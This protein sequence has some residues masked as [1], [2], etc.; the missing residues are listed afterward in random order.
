MD[1]PID[2]LH[3]VFDCCRCV[4][5]D[6]SLRLVGVAH[7]FSTFTVYSENLEPLFSGDFEDGTV[8]AHEA[9]RQM[10]EFMEECDT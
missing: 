9:Q 6:R 1:R 2:R 7:N 5:V 3:Y 8:D 10:L 4:V